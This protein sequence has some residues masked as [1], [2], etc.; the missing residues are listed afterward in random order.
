MLMCGTAHIF[1]G[2]NIIYKKKI[3]TFLLFFFSFFEILFPQDLGI[4]QNII[5]DLANTGFENIRIK[6]DPDKIIIAYENRVYRFD[7]DAV[8]EVLKIV[9]PELTEQ[10][11]IIL[12]PENRKIPLVIIEVLVTDCKDYLS[13][14]ISGSEFAEKLKIIFETDTEWQ[15]LKNETEFNSSNLR[16]DITLKPTIAAQFGVFTDPVMWQLN[17]VPGIRTS[18][19]KGMLFNYELIVPIHNDL[20][21]M[22]DS[23]RT[24]M[25]VIN[26]TLRLPNSFFVSSSI[27]YF[28]N[29]RY[30]FDIEAKKYFSNGDINIGINF[31]ITSFAYFV[32]KRFYY[33]D[34]FMW[35]G[36]I[37]LDFRIPKYDLTLG[38]SSGKFLMGDNSIRLDINRAFGEI[39]IGFFAIRSLNG[40]SNGGINISIPIFPSKYWK[41]SFIRLRTEENFGWG[42][43]VKS[44]TPDLIGLRYNTGNKIN[45]F[46]KKLNPEFIKNNF[47]KN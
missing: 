30:G 37:N 38:L 26:Q 6:Y 8:K 24:G 33:S 3:I 19:W 18:F 12:I 2:I 34:Q 42:Y 9:V 46:I 47:R 15:D 40:I 23:V 44:N 7:V 36:G 14:N 5:K 45:N 4:K 27:G 28:S 22:E 32:G 1:R 20:L 35:T 16:F 11:K 43:I 21:P 10:K 31:G 25:A 39:E 29:N 13:S 41:P 17:L